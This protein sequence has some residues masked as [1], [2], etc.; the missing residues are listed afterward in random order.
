[1]KVQIFN[2]QTIMRK[3][4]FT[5]VALSLLSMTVVAQ[6]PRNLVVVEVGTGTWCQFCPGAAMGCEDLLANGYNVAIV[7]YHSGDP[8]ANT[9]S[10]SRIGYYATESLP[11]A[12]FDGLNSVVGGSNTQSLFPQYSTKVTQRMAIMSAFELSLEGTHSCFESFNASI[13]LEKVGTNN[14]SNLRLHAVVT[15]SHIPENWQG[16]TEVNSATRLMIPN[17]SGTAVSF[18]GGNTQTFDLQ[19][20]LDPS[21]VFEECELVV[22]LQDQTTKEIFQGAKLALLDFMPEYDYDATVK[23]LFNLPKASCNGS[24]T[25][26]VM[27]RNIGAMA[28]GNV[29]IVYQVNNGPQQV[30]NWTGSLNYLGEEMVALPEIT[31]TGEDDNELIVYTS[32]PNG[33]PDQCPDND[34]YVI[35]IPESMHTPNT[36]KLILRTDI[37]P[38]ETTWELTNAAG[39]IVDS[40]GPYTTSGQM[41]QKTFDLSEEACYMF[42]IHDAGG[43]GLLNPGFYMLYHGSNT[44]ISQGTAFGSEEAIEFN[45][46]DPVGIDEIPAAS[47][48]SVYPNP[49]VDKA[50]IVVNLNEDSEVSYRIFSASG[51]QMEEGKPATMTSGSHG[52]MVDV[53]GWKPGLYIYKVII[54]TKTLS[55]KFT[56]K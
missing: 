54:G 56:V 26:E 33:N 15:E 17:Q 35:S 32:N 44:T 4:I 36:V 55:G 46:A 7:K 51:Q 10:N 6:V 47:S 43:D 28:M 52:I 39:E 37:N 2:Y 48:V 8:Y 25:P 40:G 1:M 18:A 41:V 9:Y 31:F 24:F 14:S 19:F 13:T 3:I 29:D 20:T 12:Y 22:F 23:N 42:T 11:T 5:L 30:Y 45:T 16:Q 53:E 38:G 27:I 34:T 50:S 21:W 49:A